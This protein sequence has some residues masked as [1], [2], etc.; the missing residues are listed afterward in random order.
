MPTR[1]RALRAAD[2]RPRRRLQSGRGGADR[3]CDE[4]EAAGR[5]AAEAEPAVRG[6]GARAAEA[7]APDAA[8]PASAGGAR[9][10]GRARPDRGLALGR[11]HH[12]AASPPRPRSAA[13][14]ATAAT[15]GSAR[16][17]PP[18]RPRATA[19]RAS[20][21]PGSDRPTARTPRTPGAAPAESPRGAA[22]R[23]R[24]RARPAS[25]GGGKDRVRS[26]RGDPRRDASG[27]TGAGSDRREKQPDPN[28]PFA[29]LLALKAQLEDR[30]ARS[31]G[32][33]LNAGGPA[34]ARQVAVVRALREDPDARPRSSSTRRLRP[35]QRPS[36][37][38]MPPRP[39]AV[40]DVLTLALPRTTL[41]VRID[42]DSAS[43]ARPRAGGA[44]ASTRDLGRDDG[45]AC[46]QRRQ[47]V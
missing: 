27:P 2:R 9:G 19:A 28:S 29:K 5:S 24:R 15:A 10:R 38:T 3:G 20:G 43:A 41:V 44:A 39:L 42:A 31:S 13:N 34:A 21:R 7:A 26:D 37:A 22:R 25:A 40:G 33:G 1:H 4:A 11:R 16:K 32:R 35:R 18:E 47:A 17:A 14:G 12:E 8:R 23:R 45:H 36:A 6:R 46:Q 30:A